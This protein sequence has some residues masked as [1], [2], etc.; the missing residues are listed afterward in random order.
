MKRPKITLNPETPE[1]SRENQIALLEKQ[2]A[3]PDCKPGQAAAISRQLAILRGDITPG[4]YVRVGATGESIDDRKRDEARREEELR[5]ESAGELPYWWSERQCRIRLF[6]SLCDT[7]SEPD[8]D[9]II[10]ANPHPKN[11]M[12]AAI[13]NLWLSLPDSVKSRL[14]SLAAERQQRTLE[15]PLSGYE[16]GRFLERALAIF[17][18]QANEI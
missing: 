1:L 9:G 4:R 15:H 12:F 5:R 8:F 2:L 14:Q 13:N 7:V 16:D 11:A 18:P 3:S 6:Y 10:E 17:V